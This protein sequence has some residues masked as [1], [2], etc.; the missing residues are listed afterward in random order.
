MR[1][2]MLPVVVGECIAVRE[3]RDRR[4]VDAQCQRQLK[5]VRNKSSKQ[6]VS[7]DSCRSKNKLK[8]GMDCPH[9][10]NSNLVNSIQF[11]SIPFWF[12][13]RTIGSVP[14]ALEGG[15]SARSF[16]LCLVGRRCHVRRS[17]ECSGR[18][19]QHR[20]RRRRSKDVAKHFE[21]NL[22]VYGLV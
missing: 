21:S 6:I 9:K 17:G 2:T 16:A 20:R 4:R 22:F 18:A 1:P 12:C 13:I 10:R 7:V 11:H 15:E 19:R 8:K 3:K 5:T 14:P